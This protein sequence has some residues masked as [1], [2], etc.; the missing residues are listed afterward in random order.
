MN[1]FLPREVEIKGIQYEN[2]T[3]VALQAKPGQRVELARDY[4]NPLDRNAIAVHLTKRMIGYI[5]RQVA[6]I[7][8]P[9]MDTE[10][11]IQATVANVRGKRPPRV[12][13]RIE[14]VSFMQII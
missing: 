8:A 9:E 12:F 2:R 7:I 14:G 11:C 6:Q 3:V 4:D 10:T 5:P 1:E 13:V